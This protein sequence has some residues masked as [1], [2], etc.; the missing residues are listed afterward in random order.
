MDPLF[1]FLVLL[2]LTAGFV[3]VGLAQWE[4]SEEE[5]KARISRTTWHSAVIPGWGQV[6]NGKWWKVP[7][8]YGALGAS[9]YF[10]REEG[11]LYRGYRDGY[12]ALTDDDPAT[13]YATQLTTQQVLDSRDFHRSNLEQSILTF[14]LLWGVQVVDAHVDAHLKGFDVSENLSYV[15]GVGPV[16]GV[17]LTWN[18]AVRQ[19]GR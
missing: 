14:V 2:V 9:G 11:A 6:D 19:N 12:L 18:L 17:T 5:R 7:L 15:P 1:R 10:I 8:V 3:P 13:Q 4:E 16:G